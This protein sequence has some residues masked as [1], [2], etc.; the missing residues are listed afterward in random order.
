MAT[1][2]QNGAPKGQDKSA[3]KPSRRSRGSKSKDQDAT[4]KGSAGE[5]VEQQSPP[6]GANVKF[7]AIMSV[8]NARMILVTLGRGNRFG[9]F[10]Q[11]CGMLM[12]K[13]M[14]ISFGNYRP[15][16]VLS[17]LRKEDFAEQ[18]KATLKAWK[19]A[20]SP[21]V[22]T[23]TESLREGQYKASMAFVTEGHYRLVADAVESM[24]AHRASEVVLQDGAG[25][26]RVQNVIDVL[27]LCFGIRL[28][29]ARAANL[30]LKGTR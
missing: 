11:R 21:G 24:L 12:R 8:V 16:D 9:G 28:T 7:R 2:L 4:P 23:E 5:Q 17:A 18:F 1:K 25:N 30:R 20:W 3:P 27:D 29:S 10:S 26:T 22:T 6:K 15:S 14:D 13:L 19:D